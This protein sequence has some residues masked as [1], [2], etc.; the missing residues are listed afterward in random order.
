MDVAVVDAGG[1]NLGSICYALERLGIPP[2]VVTDA[3]GLEN[4][5]R[6]ILPG[7]GAAAPAMARLREQGLIDPLRR[8]TVPVLGICLGM[9]LLYQGSEEGGT[10]CLGILAGRIAQM[11]TLPGL[12]I[13]HMGWNALARMQRVPLV[14][15][16]KEGDEVYFVHRYAASVGDET[17][18]TATH[19]AAFSAIVQVRNFH[20]VQFHPERSGRIGARLLANFVRGNS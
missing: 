14:E 7:V 1:A 3:A 15:G 2:R 9:Q 12:R 19:G 10:E 4:A 5:E 16:V 6:V 13:P 18:A 8:L 20:G 17:I 11:R